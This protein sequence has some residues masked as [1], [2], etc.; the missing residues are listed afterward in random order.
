MCA[1]HEGCQKD[2]SK[3]SSTFKVSTRLTFSSTQWP[4]QV[5]GQALYTGSGKKNSQ[6]TTGGST[7]KSHGKLKRCF[8]M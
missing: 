5:S 1:S 3:P 2:K 8:F 4:K 7:I 6:L